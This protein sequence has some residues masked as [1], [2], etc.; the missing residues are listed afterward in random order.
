MTATVETRRSGGATGDG[1]RPAARRSATRRHLTPWMMLAPGIVLFAVFMAAPILYTV[2][3][4]PP[5][6]RA[7]LRWNPLYPF[8]AALGQI[9][10]ARWPSPAYL[11]AAT[12]WALLLFFGG[13]IAF[14]ARERDFAVRL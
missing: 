4:I 13:A 8:Y 12:G 5:N 7:Y 6:L 3:E 10:N 2:A 9:F 14:L 11:A 1:A